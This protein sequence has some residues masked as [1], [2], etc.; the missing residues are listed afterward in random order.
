M[1]INEFILFVTILVWSLRA[2]I[3]KLQG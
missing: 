2:I 1:V 3:Y